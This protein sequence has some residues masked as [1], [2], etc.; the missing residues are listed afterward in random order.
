MFAAMH[1]K[2][3]ELVIE[4]SDDDKTWKRYL[5]YFKVYYN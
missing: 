1:D 3:W 2:R 4:G 5:F